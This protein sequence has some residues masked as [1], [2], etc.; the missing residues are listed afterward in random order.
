VARANIAQLLA[1]IN[2]VQRLSSALGGNK[3]T[4]RQHDSAL[5]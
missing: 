3:D 4:V 2:T 5:R 1:N